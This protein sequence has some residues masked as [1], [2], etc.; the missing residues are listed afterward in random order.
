MIPFWRELS[1][2]VQLLRKAVISG[3]GEE[4]QK[5]LFYPEADFKTGKRHPVN[6]R[7]VFLI[8]RSWILSQDSQQSLALLLRYDL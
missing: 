8:G 7:R 2:E 1:Q 6:P 5:I 4:D 3:D